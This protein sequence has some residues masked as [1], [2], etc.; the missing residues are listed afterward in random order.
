MKVIHSADTQL[1]IPGL[2]KKKQKQKKQTNIFF[3]IFIFFS[4]ITFL[5]RI[6]PGVG[7][8]PLARDSPKTPSR[9]PLPYPVIN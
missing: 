2:K 4:P 3:Y 1:S 9:A 6:L 8:S 5:L 7:F